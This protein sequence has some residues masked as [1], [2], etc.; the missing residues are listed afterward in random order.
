M[1]HLNH[2]KMELIKNQFNENYFND[3]DLDFIIHS[4]SKN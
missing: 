2:P 1:I 4:K 3:N